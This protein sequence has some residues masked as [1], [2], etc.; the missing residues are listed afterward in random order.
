[1]N[2]P[3][4]SVVIT[5][6]NR[7]NLVGRAI[8]SVV[9]QTYGNLELHVVDDSSID[10]TG[11]VV[12]SLFENRSNYFY[13]RHEN[14][15]GLAAA[16]NTGIAKARGDYI[17]FLDD[18]DEW[19][20]NKLRYQMDLVTKNGQDCE[21]IYC[22]AKIVDYS[23]RKIGYY[24]PRIKGNIR[25]GIVKKYLGTIP[26][27]CLFYADSLRSIGGY[28][29]SLKSHIDH[30]IWMKMAKMNYCA[31]YVDEYL[32]VCYQL[33]NNR[34]TKNYRARILATE[35]YINK[36]KEDIIDWFGV[37]EGNIYC[38]IYYRNVVA[39]QVINSLE[40]GKLTQA[41]SLIINY[42]RDKRSK[43]R[44]YIYITKR[45]AKYFIKKIYIFVRTMM[46]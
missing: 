26:S 39:A 31:D 37:R 30:D 4:V 21:V 35:Q 41:V 36:W 19:E 34:M 8:S 11:A 14:N 5:T 29:E 24:K 12:K 1:M 2:K 6:Y 9:E 17:A 25:A 16:R 32:V 44:D 22:G 13:W 7:A 38:R 15:K 10:Q 18:D 45:T 33:K 40:S 23:G 20:K 46:L 3:K 42:C 28:D 43:I 27:S